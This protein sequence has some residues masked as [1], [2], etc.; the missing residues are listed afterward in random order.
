MLNIVSGLIGSMTSF[1]AFPIEENTDAI[2]L[3]TFLIDSNSNH[4]PLISSILSMK[5]SNGIPSFSAV[6]LSS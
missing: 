3:P 6:S 4:R 5:V 1:Q 2:A